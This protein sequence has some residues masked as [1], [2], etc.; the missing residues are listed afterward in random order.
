MKHIG[1]ILPI[2]DDDRLASRCSKQGSIFNY[3]FFF[4]FHLEAWNLTDEKKHG[5]NEQQRCFKDPSLC[6]DC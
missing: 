6:G 4:N 5:V 3:V 1:I 2:D